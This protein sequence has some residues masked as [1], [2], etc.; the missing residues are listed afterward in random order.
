[1]ATKQGLE[2][3]TAA[4]AQKITDAKTTI[5]ADIATVQGEQVSQSDVDAVTALG[6]QVDDLVS[7]VGT[8]IA[9]PVTAPVDAPPSA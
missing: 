2:T 5:L 4:T 7:S 9:P 3:A 8:A 6:A 1:M